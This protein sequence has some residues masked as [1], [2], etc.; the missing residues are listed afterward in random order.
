MVI[1]HIAGLTFLPV[2]VVMLLNNFGIMH[3]SKIFCIDITL[4][5]AL[6]LI[7]VEI[8]DII[9]SHIADQHVILTWIVGLILLFPSILYFMSKAMT[10]L[11]AI[12]S[13]VPIIIAAFLINEGLGSV[14]IGD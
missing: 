4:L 10:L 1:G 12:V 11:P 7:I 13:A 6:G 8:T 2:G 5:G 14:F 9:D 3:L